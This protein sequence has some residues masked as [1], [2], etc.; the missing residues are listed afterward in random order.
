MSI[1]FTKLLTVQF[2]GSGLLSFQAAKPGPFPEPCQ[3]SGEEDNSDD[4][5][6]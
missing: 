4:L 2:L 5:I 6:V 1:I 3:S